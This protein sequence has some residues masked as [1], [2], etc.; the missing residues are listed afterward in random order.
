MHP[1]G[2]T[3]TDDEIRVSVEAGA[4][5][6]LSSPDKTLRLPGVAAG[7]MPRLL[8]IRANKPSGWDGSSTQG[9]LIY[10]TECADGLGCRHSTDDPW[11]PGFIRV[12][13]KGGV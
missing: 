7:G 4:G 5:S 9:Y 6:K 8:D 2:E 13:P 1:R 12:I 10:S 11:D 3:M